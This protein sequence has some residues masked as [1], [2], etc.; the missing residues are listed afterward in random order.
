MGER[1]ADHGYFRDMPLGPE[2]V[3][4]PAGQ[5]MMGAAPS[6]RNVQSDEIPFHR[7]SIDYF[8]AV[9]RFP[10]TVADWRAFRPMSDETTGTRPD[11][12]VT[13]VSYSDAQA[14]CAWLRERTGQSYRLLSE[15]EW[16]YCAGPFDEVQIDRCWHNHSTGPLAGPR[17]VDAGTRNKFGLC[18]MIGNVWEW[19]QDLYHGDYT[20][21]PT[22]GSAW[23]EGGV[24]KLA[25]LKGGS[26]EIE[27]RF[28]R[29][30]FRHAAVTSYRGP[31]V[32][33]RIARLLV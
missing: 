27:S 14:Y 31:D 23:I 24:Q 11:L 7:V 10:I 16:E 1:L 8:L 13:G 15:A 6:D 28:L 2:M 22:D 12:P 20:N 21:A 29:P 18:E 32:G 5:F 25:V 33:F 3:R 4:M 9:S 19:V 26:W 30:A 17:P